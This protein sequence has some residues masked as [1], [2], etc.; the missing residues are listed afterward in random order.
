MNTATAAEY[1]PF[2]PS[3]LDDYPLDPYEFRLYARINRRGG[4]SSCWESIKHMA[5]A[6]KMSLSKAR[7]ALNFLVA[8][9]LVTKSERKGKTTEWKINH[10]KNWLEVKQ[11]A[12]LR[13][14]LKQNKDTSTTKSDRGVKCDRGV[15]YG[16]TKSDITTP[17]TC[18]RGVLSDLIHEGTPSI[19]SQRENLEEEKENLEV[20]TQ[21]PNAS[22]TKISVETSELVED[23]WKKESS[24]FNSQIPNVNSTNISIEPSEASKYTSISTTYYQGL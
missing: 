11:L 9:G 20:K 1:N 2:I 15:K 23:C 10:P 17:T 16:S 13:K 8:C 12:G 5:R 4:N 24:N 3:V 6:T 14:M 21:K 19:V 22:N 18:D 7:K